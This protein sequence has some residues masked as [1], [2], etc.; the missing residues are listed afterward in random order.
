MLFTDIFA[1]F[2]VT[3]ASVSAT[4]DAAVLAHQN[5]TKPSLHVPYCPKIGSITYNL[6]V[7][8][9]A[10]FPETKVSLCYDASFI[11]IGFTALEEE[12][13]YCVST[14]KPPGI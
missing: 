11:Y 2:L 4:P 3:A 12:N 8:G 7:P 1:F 13:F 10:P 9:L 14:L 6:S 5:I